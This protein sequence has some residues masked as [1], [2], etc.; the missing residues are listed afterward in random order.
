MDIEKARKTLKNRW[1][2]WTRYKH[3]YDIYHE[4]QNPQDIEFYFCEEWREDPETFIDWGIKAGWKP[5][6]QLKRKQI[7]LPHG[8]D[9]SYW[10]EGKERG[11]KQ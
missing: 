4:T 2:E 9:N 3:T 10:V 8:P 7:N 6:S 1:R 5:W 11:V